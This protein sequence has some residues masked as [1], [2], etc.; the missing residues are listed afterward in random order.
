MPERVSEIVKVTPW[1]P[2]GAPLAIDTTSAIVWPDTVAPAPTARVRPVAEVTLTLLA[3]HA[4]AL[5]EVM[6]PAVIEVSVTGY[7]FGLARENETSP[8]VKPGYRSAVAVAEVTVIDC[9]V[10]ARA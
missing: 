6:L 10:N 2:S 8:F 7:G 4:A 3:G 1:Q 9:A 5:L